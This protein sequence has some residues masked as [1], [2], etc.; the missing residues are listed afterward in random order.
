[1]GAGASNRRQEEQQQELLVQKHR[2]RGGRPLF[3]ATSIFDELSAVETSN[4]C[5]GLVTTS[6]KEKTKQRPAGLKMPFSPT[7]P[8]NDE[9]LLTPISPS[10]PSPKR[11]LREHQQPLQKK[12]K[13]KKQ[14]QKDKQKDHPSA[15]TKIVSSEDEKAAKPK[16]RNPALVT[17]KDSALAKSLA[18][19]VLHQRPTTSH[20]SGPRVLSEQNKLLFRAAC[21]DDAQKLRELFDAGAPPD[22]RNANGDSL[23]EL[24]KERKRWRAHALIASRL[25]KVAVAGAPVASSLTDGAAVSG[26]LSPASPNTKGWVLQQ[27]LDRRSNLVESPPVPSCIEELPA[28]RQK[29]KQPR[30]RRPSVNEAVNIGTLKLS[31]FGAQGLLGSAIEKTVLQASGTEK[32]CAIQGATS[33]SSTKNVTSEPRDKHAWPKTRRRRPSIQEAS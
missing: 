26:P 12:K 5:S 2:T 28:Q 17:R 32:L 8:S 1:M 15:S 18:R 33:N 7:S 13:K 24:A 4:S 14:K 9:G 11:K 3:S 22:A 29:Q 21:Q 27:E 30:R 16:T 6:K 25:T 23:I 10:E 31:K 19:S 20:Q